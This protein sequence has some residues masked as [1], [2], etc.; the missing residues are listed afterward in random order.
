LQNLVVTS[1]FH[2]FFYRWDRLL[3]AAEQEED[4]ETKKHIELLIDTLGPEIHSIDSV[5]KGLL[6]NGVI[7]Y[8][9]LWTLFE[10]GALLYAK[11]HSFKILFSAVI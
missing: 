11:R 10:P 4:P 5:K 6:K 2:S 8:E 3:K 9:E 7:T 1:P